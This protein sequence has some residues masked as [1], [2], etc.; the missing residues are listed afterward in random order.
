M[1]IITIIILA[2]L[3]LSVI[4]GYKKGFLKTAFSLVAW[5]VVLILCNFVTPIVTDM[6]VEKTE[7]EVVV[8]KT[9]DTKIDQVI[10]E[11]INETIEGTDLAEL[12]AALPAEL[13]DA[14][15]G[16]NGSLQEVVTNGVDLDTAGLVNGIVG[17]LGFVITVIVLR[18]AMMVVE[19]ALNLVGKLPLIGPMDK[20]L[21][22][23]CGAGKGIILCW[24]ILAVV[25]VLALTGT[26]TELAT[27]ISQSELLTWLQ[28]NNVLLNLILD[29]Q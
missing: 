28:D 22:L 23:A 6:L 5:I 15:L 8:Q 16:E 19:L 25:S 7:I 14:L 10:N 11:T 20:I 26:N 21:G 9:V 18:L 1:N 4:G 29:I 3:V 2:V 13:K 17:I 27:Y 24:V 12:E